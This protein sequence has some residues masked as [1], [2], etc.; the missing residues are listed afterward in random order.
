MKAADVFSRRGPE[1]VVFSIAEAIAA[2]SPQ[3]VHR[4]V[5]FTAKF[6]IASLDSSKL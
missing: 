1:I 3:P 4:A 2:P 5:L 6:L